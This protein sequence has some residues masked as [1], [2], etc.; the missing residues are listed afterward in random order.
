MR[1][2][3]VGLFAVACC[4]IFATPVIAQES[5]A[6]L[7]GRVVDT[8]DA[9]VPG[10]T[11][12]ITNQTTGV[13]RQTVSNA[14]G[15]YF[16]TAISPGVY[17]LVTELSGFSKYNRRDVRLDLGR[18]TTVDVQLTL[19]E[20]TETVTI[21]AETPLVDVTSKEIGGNVTAREMSMLP[22]VNGNFIGAVAL[23]PGVISNISTESFGS[24]AISVNGLDSRN[25][26]FMLDGANNNDDVIGQR[27]GSQARAPVEAVAEFQVVTNQYDAEFGRTT[28]AIVNAISKQGTNAFHGVAAGLWQD[29]SMTSKDFFVTQNGLKK[30]DTRLQTYRANLGG[31]VVRD[32]AHFFFNLE[33]V[34]ID[35]A[36]TITIP[37]HTEFNASP[38]TQDRVWNTLARFDHQLNV[39]HTWAIR[40]LRESSPQL[41]QIVPLTLTTPIIVTNLPVTTNAAREE[42]DVDQTIVGTLNSVLGNSR[43]NTVR[44]N[45]T[46]ED[47][48]FA[49]PNFNSNGHDQ[50][51]LEP[52]LIY[53][54]FADQQSEVAQARVNDAYQVDDT[55][56]WYITGHGGTHDLKFGGQYEYVGAQSTAQD[57]LNGTFYFRTDAFFTAADP[58]TYPERLQIRVPGALNRYQKAHFIGAFVQ[59]K[60]RV[61]NRATVSLGLRYDLE[62]QPIAEVDNPAFSDP[63]AYPKDTNNLAPRVGMTYDLEGNGRGVLRGGY[64]RF[65][66]KTH[67]ELISAVLTA[68]AFSDSFVVLFPTNNA[69][70]GPTNG[71]IPSDPMLAGGPTVNRA[72]LSTLYPPGSRVK[73]TGTVW[74]DNPDR[75]I[76]HTDQF[77]AG[78]ERQ[79]W[80]TLSVSADYVHARA[81][82]QFMVQDLNP[83][84]RATTARTSTL[85]RINPAYAGEVRQPINAAAIDYDAL[86]VAVVK[87]FASDY[88]FRVSYTLGSSRGNTTGN[89]IPLSGFQVLDDLNLDANEGPTDVDRRHNLVI[90]GQ[91]VVPKTGGLTTA[92]VVRAL[93]GSKFTVLDSSTDPDRNGT[94]AEPLPAG[95]YTS[96]GR[97]PWNVY[98]EGTRNGATGPGLFQADVRLGYRLRPGSGSSLDFF[99]DVFNVTNR[100]NFANPTGDRRSTDFLNLVALRAGAVPTTV[101]LGVRMQF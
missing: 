34:M 14:D 35:R 43:L 52:R 28:G 78:Y 87:R 32:K 80:N 41:N 68:G 8:Q 59:D 53:L 30:P 93:S 49:N 100:A 83:G 95:P 48:S 42:N 31:P 27:A 60:W 82:D 26:N 88:S 91:A 40:W 79:L 70:P 96:A 92:W 72:L 62:V 55:M 33:R 25:N 47:V 84:L 7:R 9:P 2:R 17:T 12:A 54:T 89:G 51:V 38:V 86:E 66:D 63:N 67:F 39:N 85:V 58:R 56:S 75:V 81:R 90:S 16:I 99:V 98:S 46:Q 36:N 18:T 74:L 44:V 10:A 24:D 77:T 76:P 21:T 1:H 6:E 50:G 22:S 71:A 20:L 15:T 13:M 57:N 101:Q 3:P 69:D 23:L 45:F 11:I 94:F 4:V 19:G 37:A 64:G 61:T 97:N 29:A 5:T 65:Y 73:N